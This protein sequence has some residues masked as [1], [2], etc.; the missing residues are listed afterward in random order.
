MSDF[1]QAEQWLDWKHHNQGLA[2]STI[3]KYR[4]HLRKLA[5]YL[6][7]EHSTDLLGAT[8]DHLL[9]FTGLF[10]HEKGL[11]PRSRRGVVAA[12]IGFYNWAHDRQLIKSPPQKEL[13]YPKAGRPL[14]AVAQLKTLETI[15]MRCDLS[16]L[17]GIR[18]CAIFSLLAGCGLR[19]SEV[20]GLNESSLIWETLDDKRRLIVKVVGKG[21][22]ERM[23]P[24]PKDT[25]L[26]INAYKGHP[27]LRSVDRYLEKGDQVLFV[28][29]QNRMVSPDKYH[30]E[31]RRI[32]SKSILNRIKKYGLDAGLPEK[33][34]HPHAFRHLF[35]T[36]L[37]ED[38]RSTLEIQELMGH[39][40]PKTAEI[41]TH[42][43]MRRLAQIVDAANPLAK[44]R[45]PVSELGHILEN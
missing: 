1:E 34:L 18:D 5:D 38:G 40:D 8:A 26:L 13:E 20:C 28:S 17:V 11:S 2:A 33:E 10:M 23:L 22:K 12:V 3:N 19:V 45:T 35:G 30:G 31:A 32:T 14:P 16:T 42:L 6:Q 37:A 43:A 36:E 7:V 27:D 21:K 15:M 9:F 4:G 41:Y 24:A 25:W 29:V 44:V 39:S